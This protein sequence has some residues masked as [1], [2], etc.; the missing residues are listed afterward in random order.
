VCVQKAKAAAQKTEDGKKG[1]SQ[2][3]LNSS[4]VSIPKESGKGRLFK[5]LSP[6]SP[7]RE[8]ISRTQAP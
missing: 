1:L 8:P 5:K 7:E 6:D 3:V 2:T 4:V